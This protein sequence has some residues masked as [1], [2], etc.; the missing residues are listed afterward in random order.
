[1]GTTASRS[2]ETHINPS[3]PSD[4][5]LLFSSEIISRV[6]V[7]IYLFQLINPEKSIMNRGE[8]YESDDEDAKE[9]EDEDL[10]S[11]L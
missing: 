6:L 2:V 5:S 1:M 8:M 3:L 7:L 10:L 9:E 4:P 11:F